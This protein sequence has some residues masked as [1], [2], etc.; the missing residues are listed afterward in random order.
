VFAYV[1]EGT[2]A[3]LRGALDI[4]LRRF[5]AYRD[6]QGAFGRR[7]LSER[8]KGML[9]ERFQ[10]DERRAFAMLRDFSRN[11]GLK[12]VLVAKAVVDGDLLRKPSE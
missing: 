1:A 7:A 6:L 3:E 12:V 10:I 8:A 11:E 2:S 5:G 9:M 4:T